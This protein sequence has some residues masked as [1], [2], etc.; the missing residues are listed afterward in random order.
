MDQGA[1]FFEPLFYIIDGNKVYIPAPPIQPT[2]PALI[3]TQDSS[4]VPDDCLLAD[5]DYDALMEIYNKKLE[6]TAKLVD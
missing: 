6:H 3:T 1:A 5:S 4:A 2:A